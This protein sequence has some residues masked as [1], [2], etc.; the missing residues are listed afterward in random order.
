MT[1]KI[2]LKNNGIYQFLGYLKQQRADDRVLKAIKNFNKPTDLQTLSQ[3][4]NIHKDTV[5]KHL[6]RLKRQGRVRIIRN[7][8]NKNFV[9]VYY[10][11]GDEKWK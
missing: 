5:R 3:T 2:K 10:I 6:Y 11:G 7:P 1:K 9:L 8:A 4:L